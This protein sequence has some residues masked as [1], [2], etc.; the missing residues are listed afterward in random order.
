MDTWSPDFVCSSNID[1]KLSLVG[2]TWSPDFV[3]SSNIDVKLSLVGHTWSP[4]FVC[5][6]NIDVKLSLV[7]HMESIFKSLQ[8]VGQFGLSYLSFSPFRVA[9]KTQVPLF[10][11]EIKAD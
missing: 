8:D 9:L 3:C 10:R 1:V 4:D 7:G 5:S 6:S 11:L 2:H